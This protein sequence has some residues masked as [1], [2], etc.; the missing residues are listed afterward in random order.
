MKVVEKDERLGWPVR[1]DVPIDRSPMAKWAES[2]LFGK[3][4]D[5]PDFFGCR[6]RD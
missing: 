5:R 3:G 6:G 2:V 1:L 4:H